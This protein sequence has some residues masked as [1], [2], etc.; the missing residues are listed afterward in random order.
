MALRYSLT[1][2]VSGHELEPRSVDVIESDYLLE[3][4]SKLLLT[5]RII[6]E[7]EIEYA[8]RGSPIND[9]DIPF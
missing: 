7:K 5:V 3:V 9:N 1:L 2:T 6:S 4:L 8:K